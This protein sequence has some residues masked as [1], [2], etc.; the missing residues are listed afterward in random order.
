M[1]LVTGRPLGALAMLLG[2]LLV[3]PAGWFVWQMIHLTGAAGG[4]ARWVL[5]AT[6]MM[7]L[8]GGTLIGVGLT[9]C[10]RPRQNSN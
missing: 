9:A 10:M 4:F 8:I 7:T 2:I 6:F 1:S 5:F 3:A